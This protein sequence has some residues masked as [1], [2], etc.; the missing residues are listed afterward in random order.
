MK[1]EFCKSRSCKENGSRACVNYILSRKCIMIV[2]KKPH[3]CAVCIIIARVEQNLN[4]RKDVRFLLYTLNVLCKQ[5]I[6]IINSIN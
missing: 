4:F 3:V 6:I 1:I 5:I 2:Q